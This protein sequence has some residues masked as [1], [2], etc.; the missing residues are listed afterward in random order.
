MP[1]CRDNSLLGLVCKSQRN[2]ELSAVEELPIVFKRNWR[3]NN[4]SQLYRTVNLLPDN[5][6][7]LVLLVCLAVCCL[8][9]RPRPCCKYTNTYTHTHIKDISPVGFQRFY[10]NAPKLC[11]NEFVHSDRLP[12]SALWFPLCGKSHF[13]SELFIAATQIKMLC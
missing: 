4:P 8:A 3:V 9:Q 5:M 6:R 11:L 10:I 2:Q 12:T 1:P 13:I 7:V